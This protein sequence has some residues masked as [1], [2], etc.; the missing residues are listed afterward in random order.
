MIATRREF[1]KFSAAAAAGLVLSPIVRKL[2]IYESRAC[3]LEKDGKHWVQVLRP[4][5]SVL[6]PVA[7]HQWGVMS[8]ASV[9]LSIFAQLV[10]R[11]DKTALLRAF[12]NQMGG[13]RWTAT[14]G[15]EIFVPH[16]AEAV[17]LCSSSS[18]EGTVMFEKLS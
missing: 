8:T 10:R 1:M 5:D 7:I 6:G 16:G 14:P 4:D 17:F 3:P 9:D 18:G 2:D 11:P 15:A 12:A 13:Y